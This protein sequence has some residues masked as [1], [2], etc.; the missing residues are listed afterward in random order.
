MALITEENWRKRRIAGVER[1]ATGHDPAR[2]I[3]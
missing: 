2:K 1:Q 3:G